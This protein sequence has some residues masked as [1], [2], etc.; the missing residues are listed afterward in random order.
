[1]P[2]IDEVR[3]EVRAWLAENWDPEITVGQWWERQI[4]RAHV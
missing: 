4:G 1:M 3:S 2:T